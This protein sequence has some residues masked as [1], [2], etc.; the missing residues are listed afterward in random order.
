VGADDAAASHGFLG[1]LLGVVHGSAEHGLTW[2][3]AV[4]PSTRIGLEDDPFTHCHAISST[5]ATIT[6]LQAELNLGVAPYLNGIAMSPNQLD[7]S[8]SATD[9]IDYVVTDTTGLT[10]PFE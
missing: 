5:G 2:Q 3:Q 10:A 8:A 6:G 1:A 9:S 4:A 7:T